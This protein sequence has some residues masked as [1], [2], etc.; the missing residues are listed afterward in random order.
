M[1]I[2]NLFPVGVGISNLG[3]QLAPEETEVI[4]QTANYVT[5]EKGSGNNTHSIS[6]NHYI[7]EDSRMVFVKDFIQRQLEK[8]FLEIYAPK[9]KVSLYITESWLNY[10]NESDGL[11]Q[12]KHPNSVVSGV[13]YPK[14][15][16]GYIKF[17]KDAYDMITVEPEVYNDYNS[18]T[19]S[20]SVK[21]GDLILFPSKLEHYLDEH[22]DNSTRISLAFNTFIKGQIAT[23]DSMSLRI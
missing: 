23:T 21:E 16:G 11:H 20:L 22:K 13:F 10:Y 1:N 12:H 9:N 2:K 5:N 8:Y 3:R 15:K 18:Y 14:I 7:L 6:K 17:I 4:M 19:Y